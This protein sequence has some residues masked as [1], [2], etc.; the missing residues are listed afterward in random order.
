M[1]KNDGGFDGGVENDDGIVVEV[2]AV[3]DE[4]DADDSFGTAFALRKIE[5]E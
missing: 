3:G 5:G 4:D 1:L 2:E